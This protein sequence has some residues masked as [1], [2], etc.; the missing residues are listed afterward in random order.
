MGQEVCEEKPVGIV[1]VAFLI[2]GLAPALGRARQ[3]EVPGWELEYAVSVACARRLLHTGVIQICHLQLPV[4]QHKLSGAEVQQSDRA[5][6]GVGQVVEKP[7][8]AQ[9]DSEAILPGS[10]QQLDH[11]HRGA[12]LRD[13]GQGVWDVLTV[14][15]AVA[16]ELQHVGMP[17]PLQQHHLFEQLMG[18][19]SIAAPPRPELAHAA[20]QIVAAEV[21]RLER[22]RRAA[23]QAD[24]VH[25]LG[26]AGA[27][28]L[29]AGH[30]AERGAAQARARPGEPG[31]GAGASP[32][33]R[34]AGAG[35]AGAGDAA[36]PDRPEPGP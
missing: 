15:V 21:H 25:G 13:G 24:P 29:S 18:R 19:Q 8:Q 10:L 1:E 23:R 32:E 3:G 12:Q 6:R 30:V 7:A 14:L 17:Q 9:A 31:P 20:A 16:I 4:H 27:Q 28:V 33:R 22:H 5:Q 26:V 35:P 36:G 11:L 2:H 34:R